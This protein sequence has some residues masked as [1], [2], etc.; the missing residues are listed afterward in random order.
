MGWRVK[1][2]RVVGQ[3]EPDDTTIEERVSLIAVRGESIII[4][5]S[6]TCP[7]WKWG[8]VRCTKRL[9]TISQT[10]SGV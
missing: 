7:G 4:S 6:S 2:F 8:I 10:R 9:L 1:A 5:N 3:S